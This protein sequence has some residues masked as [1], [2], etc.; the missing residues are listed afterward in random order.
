MYAIVKTGG[1]QYRVQEGMEIDVEKIN[2]PPGET[3]DL[4]SVMFLGLGDEVKIG[5][6]Y[7]QGAKVACEVVKH[8]R[9]EKVVVFKFKRRKDY[10]RKKGHRQDFTRLRVTAIQ[11]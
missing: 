5:T 4:D 6:P 3:V 1:K 7:V 2:A 8:D 10:R 9:G 11:T